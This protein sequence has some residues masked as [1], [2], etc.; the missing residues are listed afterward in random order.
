MKSIV[1][2][3]SGNG[4][5]LQAIIDACETS[6]DTGRVTAVFSNKATAYALERAKKAGAAGH[7]LDPKA[8]ETRDAFDH[9][10]MKQIDE[11]KP[12][13]IVLAGYMRILSGEFVR[14]YMG[15]MINIHPSL[16]PKY[17]GL[18]TYQRAIHAGDEEH[19]TSVHFVTEQ[20]DGGPVI[21]QAKVPIFDEDN[22]DSL[23][24]RV[25]TQEH[26]IYPLVVKWMVEERLEMKNG[27]AFLDGEQLGIHGHAQE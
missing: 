13:V 14:H 8:F 19:G 11:Y 23:T 10:L 6:I 21:L 1:V 9:E 15:R 12:D 25:Q 5:N 18:N 27:K 17:P 7:F 16:L 20:L 4:S 2:L 26:K 3:V 24:A 22:V